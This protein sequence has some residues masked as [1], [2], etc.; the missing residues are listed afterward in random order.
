MAELELNF[1][2]CFVKQ[3]CPNLFLECRSLTYPTVSR[4]QI[5]AALED[6]DWASLL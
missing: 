4:A 2:F 3:R 6:L 1:N 5:A